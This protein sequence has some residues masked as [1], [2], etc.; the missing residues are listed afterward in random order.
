MGASKS[1]FS[2]TLRQAV[3]R[4]ATRRSSTLR[5]PSILQDFQRND[6]C[7]APAI[8]RAPVRACAA[9]LEI[10]CIDWPAEIHANAEQSNKAH[11]QRCRQ[12]QI[13]SP[14][15]WS[16]WLSHLVEP[17]RI[18]SIR[19]IRLRR[20]APFEAVSRDRLDFQAARSLSPPITHSFGCAITRLTKALPSRILLSNSTREY[21][22][23]FTRRCSRFVAGSSAVNRSA[24]EIFSVMTIKST[25]LV[26]VS[27]P[28][29]IE[30]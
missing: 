14:A 5:S 27:L 9:V 18:A 17:M 12:D 28:F 23:G 24:Y 30:P 29:A 26:A 8:P 3:I 19:R 25:S 1:S 7:R 4:S 6:I 2:T 13:D 11:V 21:N 16:S 15:S 22:D 10:R 20:A